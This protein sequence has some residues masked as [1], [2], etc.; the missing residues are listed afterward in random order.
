MKIVVCGPPHSGKSVFLGG[1]CA[2]L[3]RADRYLFR[4]CPD[5]EGTWTWKGS[6]AEEYRRKGSFSGSVVDWYV[7]SLRNC[8]LAPIILVDVG[9][10]MSEENRRI[11]AECDS[12]IILSGDLSAISSWQAFC[13]EIGLGILAVLHSDYSG[14]ADNTTSETM[15]V[16]HLERGEDTSM[17]PAIQKVAQIVLDKVGVKEATMDSLSFISGE[18][19]LSIP[20]LAEALGKELQERELPNKKVIRQLV[21]EGSDLVRITRLL[22]NRVTELPPVVK[23]DGAAPAW[24][25][26]ALVHEVHPRMAAL[27]SPDGYIGVEGHR[28]RT[29]EGTG[30]VKFAVRPHATADGWTVV[31]FTLDPSTPLDPAVLG[32]ITP[33]KLPMGAKVVI[34]GRGPNWLTASIAMGYH[35]PTAAVA[36]FQPGTGS[37]VCMTHTATVPLGM[38][39]PGNA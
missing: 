31:E 6:G 2:N 15:V 11:M 25:A 39:I 29:T 20:A 7:Q 33:P 18:G 28:A 10:R 22:H 32:E 21:W 35:G 30:P 37:T 27:N 13:Q 3:P 38:L 24:L 1:L 23:I 16:H 5:G 26:T 36:C 9:G 34:S 4:A 19:V 8:E 12:A 17:R 14:A